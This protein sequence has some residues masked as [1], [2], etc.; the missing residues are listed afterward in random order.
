MQEI[1]FPKFYQIFSS[2]G[3]RKQYSCPGTTIW[4]GAS[5][6]VLSRLKKKLENADLYIHTITTLEVRISKKKNNIKIYTE[7]QLG[8]GWN[9]LGDQ[10]D[11]QSRGKRECLTSFNQNESN[12]EQ[13]LLYSN[14]IIVE[15]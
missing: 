11:S 3:T 5:S 8:K 10:L 14:D 6:L 12:K 15:L 7:A 1:S 4:E 2:N 13:L 9:K